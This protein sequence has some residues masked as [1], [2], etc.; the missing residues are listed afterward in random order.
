[1]V[2]YIA[3]GRRSA[4]CKLSLCLLGTV[5]RLIPSFVGVFPIINTGLSCV[6]YY[7][8]RV[9]P[10]PSSHPRPPLHHT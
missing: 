10:G 3:S 4:R 2:T 9:L 5:G 1:M 7:G 8:L 6:T